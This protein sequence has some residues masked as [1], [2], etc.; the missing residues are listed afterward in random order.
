MSLADRDAFVEPRRERWKDLERMLRLPPTDAEG[1]ST[2]AEHYRSVCADLARARSLGL[3]PDVQTFLDDL[4]GRAHN[5]LYSVRAAGLGSNLIRDIVIEFPRE[6]RRQW[7]FMLVATLLFYGPFVVGF[8]GAFTS[9]DF[10]GMVL[11]LQELEAMQDSYAGSL[12]RTFGGDAAMA[13]TYVL[14]NVGIAFRTF[15]TGA[16]AGLGSVFFLAYNGL[17]IGTQAGYLQASGIL[18][19]RNNF[20]EFVSGHSAWELTGLCVSGA[21]GLLLGWTLFAPQGTTVSNSMRRAAP[22]LYRLVLGTAFMITVAATIE[23]F[24][25][26]G[27]APRIVKLVFGVVQWG[28]VGSWFVFGGR[29]RT[30]P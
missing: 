2:L 25:S 11:P 3:A 1:W 12:N 24:W 22:A 10:A 21:A 7:G 17:V 18:E 4:A 14:R 16:L 28:I 15:A 6:I 5:E 30:R 29:P 8:V 19:V 9:S 23:G 13:G 27:P 26:A 20:T